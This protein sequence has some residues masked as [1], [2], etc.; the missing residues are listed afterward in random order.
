MFQIDDKLPI[1]PLDFFKSRPIM[2]NN[3]R[4]QPKYAGFLAFIRIK[5]IYFPFY[6]FPIPYTT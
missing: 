5:S 3:N 4:K 2:I 1:F 6:R